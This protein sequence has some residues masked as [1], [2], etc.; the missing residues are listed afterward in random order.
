MS[1]AVSSLT[2]AIV[3]PDPT[4][5]TRDHAN[6]SSPGTVSSALR[7]PHSEGALYSAAIPVLDG[8]RYF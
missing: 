2:W 8:V 7:E 6:S 1:Q 3:L 5:C 4:H